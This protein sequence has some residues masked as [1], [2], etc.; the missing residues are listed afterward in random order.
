MLTRRTY[1]LAA[2][3]FAV[4]AI[5]GS[6][7][8]LEFTAVPFQD[9][10][11]LFSRIPYFHLGI[12]SRADFAANIL[13]FVPLGFLAMGSLR[14]DRR[15]PI[16][17]SIAGAAVAGCAFV[18]ANAIEFTQVF[19]PMRTVSGSD[20]FAES[21]GAVIGVIAWAIGGQRVT[22]AARAFLGERQRPTLIVRLLAIYAAGF[23]VAQLLPLDIAFSPSELSDKYHAGRVIVIPFTYPYES[24]LMML[25]HLVSGVA[26]A[27]PIGALALLGWTPLHGRRSV[28]LAAMFGIAFVALIEAAQLF[29]FSRYSDTTDLVTGAIG[30][31]AGIALAHVAA[32]R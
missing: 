7:V 21:V 19:L 14:A 20:V 28:A 15:G 23:A 2:L 10:I 32:Q 6:L 31:V 3:V 26:L 12:Q 17:A 1:G 30:I 9:A 8:P 11:N 25:W 27:V 16:A 5:Y 4:F 24:P 18:L 29:M 22:A 13:L